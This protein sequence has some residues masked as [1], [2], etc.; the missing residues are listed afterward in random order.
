MEK[1]QR[2]AGLNDLALSALGLSKEKI[3]SAVDKCVLA[4]GDLTIAE[5]QIA[6]KHLDGIMEEM[7]KRSPDT[8]IGTIP[9][10]L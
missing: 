9:H 10:D 8:L 6:R 1:K 4:M 2:I 3:V 5:S 7:Y